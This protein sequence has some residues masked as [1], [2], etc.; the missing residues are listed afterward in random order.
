MYA[1]GSR[2]PG[3]RLGKVRQLSKGTGLYGYAFG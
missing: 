1:P 3:L 2:K